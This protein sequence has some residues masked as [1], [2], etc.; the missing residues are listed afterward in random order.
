MYKALIEKFNIERDFKQLDLKDIGLRKKMGIYFNE[1]SL[2]FVI[3]QKSR[4]LLK[5]AARFQEIFEKVKAFVGTSFKNRIIIIDSPLCSKAE[6]EL[7]N[8]KWEV[9]KYE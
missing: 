8:L 9:I 2:L 7:E 1:H 4:V 5:D 6:K 3:S